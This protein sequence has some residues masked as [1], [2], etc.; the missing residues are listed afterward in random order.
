VKKIAI[1]SILSL[2]LMGCATFPEREEATTAN[3]ERILSSLVGLPETRAIER[4]G[5]PRSSYTLTTGEKIIQ[6][7]IGVTGPVG[8]GETYY[9]PQTTY[10]SGSVSTYG[11]GGYSGQG[12]Y[13]GTAT[14]YA[15]QTTPVYNATYFCNW[16]FIIGQDGIIKSWSHQGNY[17]R[18]N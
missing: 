17:C 16:R 1:L 6:Y 2:A 3:F 11:R 12:S 15:P 8:G 5:L 10:H 4:W 18:A 13:P 7:G 9:T 14:T